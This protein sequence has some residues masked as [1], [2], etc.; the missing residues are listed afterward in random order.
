MTEP[1]YRE[2]FRTGLA[3]FVE[4]VPP[5]PD[6]DDL[7]SSVTPVAVS[8]RK[9][10]A[11]G[12]LVGLGVA[13]VVLVLFGLAV[14][15]SPSSPSSSTAPVGTGPESAVQ[16]D[17]DAAASNAEA[18]WLL[19]ISGDAEGAVEMSHPDV[20][21]FNYQEFA[22]LIAGLG[23]DVTPTAVPKPDIGGGPPAVCYTLTGSDGQASGEVIF[24]EHDGEW[25]IQDIQS[26]SGGCSATTTTTSLVDGAAWA[27]PG[28]GMTDAF[29]ADG[30]LLATDGE[31]LFVADG[32]GSFDE[33][34]R[35]MTAVSP[36][37]GAML[38]QQDFGDSIQQGLFIQA[39][40]ADRLLVSVAE[41]QVWTLNTATGEILREFDLPT[42]YGAAGAVATDDVYFLGADTS[43]EGNTDPPHIMSVNFDDGSLNWQTSLAEGTDLQPIAPAL[44][45]DMVIFTSTLSHPGSADGNMVHALDPA[46]GSII[47]TA[48]LGGKQQFKFFPSLVVGSNVVVSGPEG[49]VALSLATG[50]QA[51]SAPD[52]QPLALGPDGRIHAYAP[53]GIVTLD[54][55]TGEPDPFIELA[56]SP[57]YAPIGL[58]FNGDQVV[59]SDGIRLR[60]FSQASGELT[61]E[62]SADPGAIVDFPILITPD[63]IAIPIGRQSQAPP[64]EREVIGLELP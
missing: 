40:F 15:L 54:P 64:T 25:L 61:F 13:V 34:P 44:A 43:S 21:Q 46:D 27:T 62:W 3:P 55:D 30:R 63:L 19:V 39:A 45:N 22:D 26:A 42:G 36:D 60:V 23:D 53:N 47:W 1:Q 29:F 12:W 35:M 51:W 59:V 28:V 48:N 11:P 18:W 9:G 50:E 24:A 6:W 2:M 16:F 8:P 41:G 52:A 20:V 7:P 57:R 37:S 4:D 14:V 10:R 33:S 58:W 56:W 32:H 38:W 5:G 49:A 31:R 17:G